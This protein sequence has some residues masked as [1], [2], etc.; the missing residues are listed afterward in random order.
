LAQIEISG[1]RATSEPGALLGYW[2]NDVDFDWKNTDT[3]TIWK[4]A[5][6]H[7][8]RVFNVYKPMTFKCPFTK[9]RNGKY[10][11]KTLYF[12][13][14]NNHDVAIS[15]QA[16]F[17]L[18]VAVPVSTTISLN[19]NLR[20]KMHFFHPQ[21]AAGTNSAPS[22]AGVL[23]MQSTVDLGAS[24]VWFP[25]TFDL[26][27]YLVENTL[28][29]L[30][31]SSIS[32]AAYVFNIKAP[33]KY[34]IFSH[35]TGTTISVGPTVS[36]ISNSWGSSLTKTKTYEALLASGLEVVNL[37]TVLANNNQPQNANY[38]FYISCTNAT[39]T[40]CSVCIFYTP[41]N[42]ATP[43]LEQFYK[44]KSSNKKM[45]FL[46]EYV[47]STLLNDR[48]VPRLITH[49]EKFLRNKR[50]EPIGFRRPQI[51]SL[52][53]PELSV[54]SHSLAVA[55]SDDGYLDVDTSKPEIKE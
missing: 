29:L 7:K 39:I 49:E 34:W 48:K 52:T 9:Q 13:D 30:I 12:C 46:M 17:L 4:N 32:Q 33:G 14:W 43:P 23:Q 24:A 21:T 16:L 6:N 28:G 3:E 42:T 36:A 54:V 27:S 2:D 19:V 35:A 10:A 37:N 15:T 31:D 45:D 40:N 51:R 53:E 18:I 44:L 5:T 38:R 47:Q 8:N 22:P 20:Y 1:G 55:Q 41:Y 26:T 50:I 25:T 11:E